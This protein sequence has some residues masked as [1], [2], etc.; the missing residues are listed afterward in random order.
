MPSNVPEQ[1]IHPSAEVIDVD[2]FDG[3]DIQVL[4]VNIPPSRLHRLPNWAA[5]NSESGSSAGGSGRRSNVSSPR[6]H[7]RRIFSPPPRPLDRSIPP[8]PRLPPHLAGQSSLPMRARPPPFPGE[9]AGVVRPIAQPFAFEANMRAHTRRVQS[10]P[11]RAAPPSHHQPAMGFG[12]AII[13]LNRQNAAT[14][15]IAQQRA[16]MDLLRSRQ[17]IVAARNEAQRR[18]WNLPSLAQATGFFTGMFRGLAGRSEAEDFTQMEDAVHEIHDWIDFMGEFGLN[19][20]WGNHPVGNWGFSGRLPT[21]AREHRP[22]DI[23]YK[24]EFTH[25]GQPQSGFTFDFSP[26]ASTSKSVIVIDDSPWP[27]S[28]S[29]E[30][31]SNVLVCAHCLDP[32]TVGGMDMGEEAEKQRRVW[33]LRCGHMLDGKCIEALTKPLPASESELV[34]EEDKADVKGKGKARSTNLPEPY[35]LLKARGKRKA[36]ADPD[37][38]PAEA[39]ATNSIRSRLRSHHSRLPETPPLV[40]EPPAPDESELP[41]MPGSFDARPIRPLSRRRTGRAGTPPIRVSAARPGRRG[42]GKGK[43]KQPVVEREYEWTCPVAGCGMVHC[44][45][46]IDGKW[47]MDRERGAIALYV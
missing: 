28:S 1:I 21:A 10:P 45:L 33:S 34:Q 20:E 22:P 5:S 24:P 23:E 46:L 9:A 44:S 39:P 37:P 13:A 4:D 6:R 30:D 42:K 16:R 35:V 11:M 38:D 32:L 18:T 19:E 43:A 14:E 2:A 41:S 8:V 31:T 12:G 40:P 3:D 27:S 7:S 15:N 29:S 17:R 25:P 47:G 26:P 36:K